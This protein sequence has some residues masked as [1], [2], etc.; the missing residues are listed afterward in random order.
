MRGLAILALVILCG[1]EREPTF[2]ERYEAAQEE[3]EAKAAEL[4][5]ELERAQ[6][7]PSD[8][9]EDEVVED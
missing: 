1:C 7:E 6:V 3:I 5:R 9:G 8:P 2:D 4:D